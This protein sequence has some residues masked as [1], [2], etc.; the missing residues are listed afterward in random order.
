MTSLS[1]S[2]QHGVC[3]WPFMMTSSN[4]NI[5]RVTGPLCGEFTGLR[6]IPHTKASDANFDVFFYLRLNK[7]LGK[8]WQGWR[9][10]TLSRPLWRHRNVTNLTPG[11]L[12]RR[13][14]CSQLT[15]ISGVPLTYMCNYVIL[16]QCPIC[17][18]SS[19]NVANGRLS[20]KCQQNLPKFKGSQ[21]EYIDLPC[22]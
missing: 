6:W 13:W 21:D 1:Q 9:F 2:C 8:Q 4:G 14:R 10:E 17:F 11:H 19:T 7:R 22:Q 15:Y 5:F 12:H 3:W 16:D 20:K 18:Y